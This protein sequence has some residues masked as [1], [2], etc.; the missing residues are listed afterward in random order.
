MAFSDYPDGTPPTPR[1]IG[2]TGYRAAANSE[3]GGELFVQVGDET[4]VADFAA[5]QQAVL[6]VLRNAGG[7]GRGP[8][9]AMRR[10]RP[11]ARR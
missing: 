7:R 11:H 5:V 4:G 10:G 1:E 6:A 3:S 2:G 8:S 9:G